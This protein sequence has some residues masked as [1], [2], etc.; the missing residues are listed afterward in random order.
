MVVT[1]FKKRIN[2]SLSLYGNKLF[3]CENPS[4]SCVKIPCFFEQMHGLTSNLF[5]RTFKGPFQ[6]LKHIHNTVL[7]QLDT[8]VLLKV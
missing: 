4:Y 6:L 8:I 2:S 3:L 7:S 5:A 1:S